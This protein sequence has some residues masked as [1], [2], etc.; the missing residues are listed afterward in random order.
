MFY[1]IGFKYR[2]IKEN[3]AQK[4]PDQFFVKNVL[5]GKRA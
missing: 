2:F 4:K 1:L 3:S 5:Q